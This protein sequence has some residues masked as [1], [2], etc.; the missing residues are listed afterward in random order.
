MWF[1]IILEHKSCETRKHMLSMLIDPKN[2]KGFVNLWISINAY[3]A[4]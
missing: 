3:G 4:Q 1:M 2:L